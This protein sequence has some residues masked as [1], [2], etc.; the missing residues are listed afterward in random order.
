MEA[1][2]GGAKI[3]EAMVPGMDEGKAEDQA[4]SNGRVAGAQHRTS[5]T[6]E[7]IESTVRMSNIHEESE[8]STQIK[9]KN[10]DNSVALKLD[11]S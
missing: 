5:R 9:S 11:N 3:P 6:L 4:L 2:F 7:N 1:D 10:R 8:D